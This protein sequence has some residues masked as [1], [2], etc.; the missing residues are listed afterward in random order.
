M[1][2]D[3]IWCMQNLV[4]I[5]ETQV[6]LFHTHLIKAEVLRNQCYLSYLPILSLTIL[7]CASKS[8]PPASDCTKDVL[9]QTGFVTA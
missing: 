1:T 3:D 6:D 5:C 7:H 8:N 4:E 9:H 2:G